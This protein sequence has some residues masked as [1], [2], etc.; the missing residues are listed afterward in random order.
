M[1]K[2]RIINGIGIVG[3]AFVW[4]IMCF[5]IFVY[6]N[7]IYGLLGPAA[8]KDFTRTWGISYAMDNATQ[9]QDILNDV[10]K[11]LL[12]LLVLD[13]LQIVK[14]LAWLEDHADRLSVQAVLF[15]Q[16]RTS[17]WQRAQTHSRYTAAVCST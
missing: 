1:R 12:I 15:G 2:T 8:E 6:G 11:G 7:I 10:F 3:T 16:A 17:I 13:A 14:P 5:F 4:A 9:W